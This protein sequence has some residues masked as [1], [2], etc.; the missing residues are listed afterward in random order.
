MLNAKQIRE[1]AAEVL[2]AGARHAKS[3]GKGSDNAALEAVMRKAHEACALFEAPGEPSDIRLDIAR[4]KLLD[5]M[6][7]HAAL[8]SKS[9]GLAPVDA[10]FGRLQDLEADAEQ[11]EAVIYRIIAEQ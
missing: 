8:A 3:P 7:R 1:L 11:L 4:E 10:H 5:V 6:E 2:E 9:A